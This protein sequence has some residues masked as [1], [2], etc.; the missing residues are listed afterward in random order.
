MPGYTHFGNVNIAQLLGENDLSIFQRSFLQK[1]SPEANPVVSG[2]SGSCRF[3]IT[4]KKNTLMTSI[5]YKE[6]SPSDLQLHMPVSADRD[7]RALGQ[8][9]TS[10]SVQRGQ[11][12]LQSLEITRVLVKNCSPRNPDYSSGAPF[13][14]L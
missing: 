7:V 4:Q 2:C 1:H 5:T 12:R 10:G 11:R 9:R 13:V 8:A 14:T 6:R 3:I